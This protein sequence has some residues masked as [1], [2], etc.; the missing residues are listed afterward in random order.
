MIR[1]LIFD[2]SVFV[3]WQPKRFLIG[4]G[5]FVD[6][7]VSSDCFQRKRPDAII[8]FLKCLPDYAA[9]FTSGTI[10]VASRYDFNDK[11]LPVFM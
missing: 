5:K 4:A 10:T 1:I 2:L 9:F 6:E 8:N 3:H 7:D 11:G